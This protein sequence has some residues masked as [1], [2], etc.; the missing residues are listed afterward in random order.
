M[1]P[2]IAD[3]CERLRV[4][5]KDRLFMAKESN[6]ASEAATALEALSAR[7]EELEQIGEA[8]K[9]ASSWLERWAVHAGNCAGGSVCT[10]GL[11]AIRNEAEIAARAFVDKGE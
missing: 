6:L 10:C 8:I 4:F 7:V 5:A 1:T 11:T 3:L 2:P 9:S